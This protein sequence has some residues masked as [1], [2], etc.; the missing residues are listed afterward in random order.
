MKGLGLGGGR[1][2]G[3]VGAVGV[4]LRLVKSLVHGS[5]V[6]GSPNFRLKYG[7]LHSM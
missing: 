7:A 5:R 3:G 4:R 1:G 6:A 2:Y